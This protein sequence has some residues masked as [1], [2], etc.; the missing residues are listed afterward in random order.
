M[1]KLTDQDIRDLALEQGY[2]YAE[3]K[4]FIM[5]ESSGT[6]FDKLGNLMIQF[7][8]HVFA[9]WLEIFDVEHT[10]T[11][12]VRDGRTTYKIIACIKGTMEPIE[13][14]NGV[15]VQSKE[16]AAYDVALKID[17]R[18]AKLSTSWGLPQILGEGYD[19]AGYASAQAMIDDF[20]ENEVNQVRAMCTF[21]DKKGIRK[22]LQNGDWYNVA[23]LY[24]GAGFIKQTDL[25]K[26][27]DTKLKA[28]YE[29]ALRDG[30][31]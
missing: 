7:E 25:S 9:K 28:A 22:Y 21:L 13:L 20:R 26:R 11:K 3:L 6:G 29:K 31:E 23:R 5:V 24:N 16:L 2:E 4:A 12:S 30:Q 18:A 14:T 8:P 1:R 27:Y 10:L 15:E 19:L 17:E